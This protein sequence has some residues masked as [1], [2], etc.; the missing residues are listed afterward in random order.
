MSQDDKCHKMVNTRDN[1]FLITSNLDL[2][3]PHSNQKSQKVNSKLHF[4]FPIVLV[5]ETIANTIHPPYNGKDI[6][7][8][9]D[10]LNL[11]NSCTCSYQERGTSSTFM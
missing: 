6:T 9:A 2:E 4:V 8:N 3:M 1:S 7:N 10:L 5:Q 11:D